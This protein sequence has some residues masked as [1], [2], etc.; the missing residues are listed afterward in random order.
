[1]NYNHF[2][3]QLDIFILHANDEQIYKFKTHV[4]QEIYI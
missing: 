3:I 4:D 1:M 2:L